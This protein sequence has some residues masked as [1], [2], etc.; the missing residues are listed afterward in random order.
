MAIRIA[1]F[2]I[3]R[4]DK[5]TRDRW[6]AA[7]DAVQQVINCVWQT[8]ETY[9]VQRSS[10]SAIRRYLA[11]LKAWHES[12][13][14][15]RGEKAKCPVEAVSS[16]LARLIRT[17]CEAIVP[18]LH[19]RPRELAVNET[20]GLIKSRK[21][22]VGNLPGWMAIL[23]CREGRPSTTRAAPIPFDRQCSSLFAPTAKEGRFRMALRTDRYAAT[24][25]NGNAKSES[26]LDEIEL[27][28]NRRGI[29]GHEAKLW[30]VIEGKDKLKGSAL[31]W[32]KNNGKWFALLAIEQSEA[33]KREGLEGTAILSP[34]RGV[35]FVLWIAGRQ[36]P[37]GDAQHV[38]DVRRSLIGGRR[39]RQQQYR[40]GRRSSKGHGRHRALESWSDRL[41]R[42][43][44]NFQTTYNHNITKQALRICA[45][46]GIAKL[47]YLQPAGPKSDSRCLS[48]LGK[49]RDEPDGWAWF[50]VATFLNYKS[51]D[52]GIQIEVRKCDASGKRKTDPDSAMPSVLKSSPRKSGRLQKQTA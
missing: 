52:A 50:Q 25:K 21:A 45:E 43:W 41:A 32:D 10:G 22:A 49:W 7:S 15:T 51:E 19:A 9:H 47:V 26:H 11:E 44:K 39:N 14:D 2:E 34:G 6:H 27:L 31:Y 5:P 38:A 33:E 46:N 4:S 48:N 20:I 37:L 3:Y 23:L 35:P 12:D 16:E 24:A 36:I 18:E 30:R 40:Y 28:T 42:N 29:K 8:W 13:K 1:K 17:A